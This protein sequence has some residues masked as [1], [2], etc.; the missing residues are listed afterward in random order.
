MDT[1]TNRYFRQ[2]GL[3]RLMSYGLGLMLLSCLALSLS[4]CSD[5]LDQDSDRVI[6]SDKDHLENA[7]D[8]LYSV[9]G[10]V[11]KMQQ[12]ADRT[13]LLGEMRGDLVDVNTNTSADIRNLALFN[14]N[15]SNAYNSP[16]EY[17]A[18]INNCNYFIAHADTA[19]RNS[20]NERIFLK[21]YA[22][23]KSFRA[24]A[25]L[26]LALNYGSVPFVTDYIDNRTESLR[27]DYPRKGIQEI[28]DYFLDDLK[29]LEQVETPNYGSVGGY[30][31][32]LYFIPI[33]F[34]EGELNLWGGHYRDAALCYYKYISTRNGSNSE[35][36]ISTNS[37]RWMEI[38]G[39]MWMSSYNQWSSTCFGA[40]ANNYSATGET[41]TIIPSETNAASAGYCHLQSLYNADNT[42][43][44]KASIIPSQAISDLSAAQD[45]CQLTSS[46]NVIY[47]PKGLDDNRTGDLRLSGVYQK[48]A[49]FSDQGR[50]SGILMSKYQ[51]GSVYL[52]R[53]T[54]VYL[55]MAEALNRAGFPRFAFQI[56]KTGIN[57]DVLRDSIMPYYPNDK[58][59]LEKF[60]FPSSQYIL[61][62][63]MQ[64]A[65]ENTIGIHSHG[66]GWTELNNHYLYPAAP[67]TMAAADTLNYE[68]EKVE[69]LIIDED[70]LEF[71]FEGQRFY[72]LMRVALR[73]NDPSYLAN[74]VYNRRGVDKAAEM[75]ALISVDLMQPANWYLH[76]NHNGK[77]GF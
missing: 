47:A 25:Y 59:W 16:A 29:G 23:M 35:Y 65:N 19:M 56:L 72:D 34:L 60:D 6:F 36:P 22:A 28:C 68:I 13:V 64:R 52:Y 75:R 7:D 27:Q 8:T 50:E 17:Y 42:N 2:S 39:S 38:S 57:N 1:N 58:A 67:A 49:V 15:D 9:I 10:V 37:D 18:V 69:D 14:I 30:D 5:F 55:H 40:T 3:C 33:Y 53:R 43:N 41:M 61:R 32:R 48:H 54:M 62:T 31:S 46:G 76:Y 12:L 24:W 4:S 77:I 44:Y 63:T 11:S 70:A 51:L 73:R 20:R 71:A 26:Q 74:R 66:S 45:Y 21:E